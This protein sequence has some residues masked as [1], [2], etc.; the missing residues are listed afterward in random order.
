VQFLAKS[1]EYVP[2]AQ[3]EH[4]VALRLRFTKSPA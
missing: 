3:G 4:A 1:L 2:A